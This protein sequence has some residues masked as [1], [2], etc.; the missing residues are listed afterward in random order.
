VRRALFGA[1]VLALVALSCRKAPRVDQR[2]LVVE[3]LPAGLP[4][5][6]D[7]ELGGAVELLGAKVEPSSGLRPGSRVELTLYWRKR[8]DVDAGFRLFTHVLDEAGERL[9]T[10][11]NVGAL[12]GPASAPRLPPSAWDE[13]KIYVDKQAFTVPFTLRTDSISIVT[14]LFRGDQRLPVTRGKHQGDR[15]L[16]TKLAVQRATPSKSVPLLWL[17]RRRAHEPV[18]ID[19]KLD[20]PAWAFAG[21]TGAFVNVATGESPGAA[22]LA[23]TAKLVFDDQNLYIG[24]DVQDEDLRGGFDPQQPDPHLWTRDC[25]EVMIDP[26]GD[27]DNLDYYELQVGPQNLIFDSQ[28]DAYNRPKGEPDGPYGHQEWASGVQSA[29]LLRGTLDDDVEDDGYVVE[30][31]IPW[32]SFKKAKRT[33]PEAT[34][35]WRMNFY[36]VQNGGKRSGDG[37]QRDSSIAWSPIFGMGNFHLASRFGRIRFAK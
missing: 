28:F 24:F 29:V 27:G 10:L 22:E 25:V 16:V 15:A 9:L 11:D 33:P 2:G 19:G 17:P 34:D 1:V 20:E 36:A 7:V 8:S 32:S 4:I 13:G 35:I 37:E 14:G 12:R 3:A 21:S 5:K 30:M 23:A 26:D 18:V 31:A 6:L